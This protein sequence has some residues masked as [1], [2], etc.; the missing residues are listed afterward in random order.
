LTANLQSA[1]AYSYDAEGPHHTWASAQRV[2][3]ILCD[4]LQPKS[5]VDVGCGVGVWLACFLQSGVNDVS[6]IDGE[7]VPR[8]RLQI[9]ETC[10]NSADLTNPTAVVISR[11]RRFDLVLSLEVAEHLPHSTSD[12]FIDLLTSLGDLVCF[13]A[14]IPG[15]G[16]YE[17][18]NEQWQSYWAEKFAARGYA[19]FDLL[20]PR[21]GGDDQVAWFYRQNVIIY[22]NDAARAKY[23]DFRGQA[24]GRQPRPKALNWVLAEH[25]SKRTDPRSYSIRD[26]VRV[27][28]HLVWRTIRSRLGRFGS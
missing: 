24:M 27:L 2:A 6:G 4:L 10:F 22:A 23:D 8:E 21:I 17:H 12:Q 5:V 7:W 19:A 14:A 9:P 18:V 25:H 26:V 1:G 13:S 15:Q 20:R 16:G 11:P 3:P 28:P